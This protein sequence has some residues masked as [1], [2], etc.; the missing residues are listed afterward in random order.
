MKMGNL[1]YFFLNII[2]FSGKKNNLVS[3][4]GILPLFGKRQIKT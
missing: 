4:A 1:Q 3:A 2:I